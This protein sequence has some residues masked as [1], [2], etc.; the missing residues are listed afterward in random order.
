MKRT[1]LPILQ[2]PLHGHLYSAF[3]LSISPLHKNFF[4]WFYS[5]YSALKVL[6]YDGSLDIVFDTGNILDRPEENPILSVT[7][8]NNKDILTLDFINTLKYYLNQSKYIYIFLDEYYVKN[9][10]NYQQEHFLKESLIYGYDDQFEEFLICGFN[11]SM[12]YGN[13]RVPYSCLHEGFVHNNYIGGWAGYTYF[14]EF[15]SNV[16]IQF[17]KQ[18]LVHF[19][20]KSLSLPSEHYKLHF[21]EEEVVSYGVSI[22]SYLENVFYHECH[23]MKDISSIR[24]FHVLWEYHN[25][26]VNRIKFLRDL[27]YLNQGSEVLLGRQVL[28]EENAKKIRNIVLKSFIKNKG[29][30]INNTEINN[31]IKL[32]QKIRSVEEENLLDLLNQLKSG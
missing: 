26:M 20:E 13:Q 12:I 27:G 15:N 2:P 32:L 18:K 28:L 14:I 30:E 3:P 24:N 4:N 8:I 23:K 31:I 29:S 22:P 17:D 25:G 6:N 9:R 16:E 21:Q 10:F 5:N 19:L 7:K 11:S 1:I